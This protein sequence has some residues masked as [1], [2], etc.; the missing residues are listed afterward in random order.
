M[1][2]RT[3]SSRTTGILLGH[4]QHCSDFKCIHSKC[5][6]PLWV[7]NSTLEMHSTIS[8]ATTGCGPE[9]FFC[10][11]ITEHGLRNDFST[12]YIPLTG[13]MHC[14]GR[15]RSSVSSQILT[16]CFLLTWTS[17]FFLL[18]V[19]PRTHCTFFWIRNFLGTSRDLSGKG[20]SSATAGSLKATG[21]LGT[22]GSLVA[23]GSL[24]S[25]DALGTMG[26]QVTIGSLIAAG[27][28]V[29]GSVGGTCLFLHDAKCFIIWTFLITVFGQ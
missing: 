7:A 10:T 19:T 23:T 8:H 9:V 29:A 11:W 3:S 15:W 16:V 21:A 5:W 20:T 27:S 2:T 28:T 25:T 14:E 12:A 24:M 17:R 1:S 18:T 26:S 4:G 22:I 13:S 6:K